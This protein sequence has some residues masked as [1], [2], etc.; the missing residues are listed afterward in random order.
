MGLT[1]GVR[2]GGQGVDRF[3]RRHEIINPAVV[4]LPVVCVAHAGRLLQRHPL[5]QPR[6]PVVHHLVPRHRLHAS[7]NILSAP[8]LVL[9]GAHLGDTTEKGVGHCSP[10]DT[11]QK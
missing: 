10:E 1:C 6:K 3:R 9:R 4:G 5:C 8:G 2:E 11:E 7:L